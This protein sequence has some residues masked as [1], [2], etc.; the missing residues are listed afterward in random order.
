MKIG[1]ISDTHDHLDNIR[2]IIKIFK[3]KN[4][5]QI[6]HAGDWVSPFTV[7][8]FKESG[9]DITGIFGNNDGDR[10]LLNKISE[11]RIQNQPH[12]LIM[13]NRKIILLHEPDIVTELAES[14]NFDLIVYGHTHSPE[15]RKIK[16]TLIINPGELCGWLAGKTTGSIVDLSLMEAEIINL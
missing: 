1:I 12:K 4:V 5:I 13:E 2:K 6:L 15:I 14:G 3:E 9:V 8:V 11:G 7:R 16:N 10:I